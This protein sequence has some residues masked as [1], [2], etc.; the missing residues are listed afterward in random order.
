[1]KCPGC[2]IQIDIPLYALTKCKKCGYIYQTSQ[3]N[4]LLNRILNEVEDLGAL[5]IGDKVIIDCLESVWNGERGVI[6]G[7]I[8]KY[9]NVQIIRDGKTTSSVVKFP[10]KHVKSQLK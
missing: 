4:Y 1:M 5:E 8:H 3:E 9:Y 6:I 7:K 10:H 2:D